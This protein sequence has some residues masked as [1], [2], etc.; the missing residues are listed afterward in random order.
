MISN[1]KLDI[2]VDEAGNPRLIK[3]YE[4]GYLIYDEVVEPVDIYKY[5]KNH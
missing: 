2:V 1:T 5:Y 3:Y 4:N